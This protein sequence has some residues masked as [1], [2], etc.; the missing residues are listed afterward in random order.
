LSVELPRGT[1]IGS[2]MNNFRW[3]LFQKLRMYYL[4]MCATSF[5]KLY[6]YKFSPYLTGNTL[7]LH[8]K[9]R[10]VNAV[11]CENNTEHINTLCGQKEEFF[12]VTAGG[13]GTG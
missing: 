8:N 6:I 11:Y 4:V 10:P 12:H 5:S 2:N 3:V 7:R 13:T 1:N 9:T